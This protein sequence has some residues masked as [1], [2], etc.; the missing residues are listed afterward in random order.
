MQNW[1]EK[2]EYGFLGY[3]RKE[4]LKSTNSTHLNVEVLV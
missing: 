4:I 2:V 3:Q 1:K